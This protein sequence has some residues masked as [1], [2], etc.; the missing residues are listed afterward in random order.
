MTEDLVVLV[1]EKDEEVGTMP[2]MMAHEKGVLHRAISVFIFSTDGKWLLQQRALHK[3]HSPGLLL[4]VFSD[5]V[6]IEKVS[7]T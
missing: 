1:N 5:P 7:K 2:K 4:G 6:G 3:Y